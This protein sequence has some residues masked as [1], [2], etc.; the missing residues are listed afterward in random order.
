MLFRSANVNGDISK[1]KLDGKK[2]AIAKLEYNASTKALFIRIEGMRSPAEIV[3]TGNENGNWDFGITNNWTINSEKEI[4][5]NGDKVTFDETSLVRNIIIEDEVS[6]S[7][8]VVNSG[9]YVFSGD[10][11]LEMVAGEL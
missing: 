1:I 10:G 7:Q 3:W 4:F 5:V 8:L 2:G 9:T 11:S 6:P